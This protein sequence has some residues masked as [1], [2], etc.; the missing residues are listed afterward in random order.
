MR[1]APACDVFAVLTS[2]DAEAFAQCGLTN[3][4]V[5]PNPITWN[6]SASFTRSPGKYI[7]FIGR[8]SPE[9]GPDLA[10][11]GFEQARAQL[12]PDTRLRMIGAGPLEAELREQAGPQVEFVAP[13]ADIESILSESAVLLLTSRTEGAPLVVAE[14]LAAGVPVIATDCSAGVREFFTNNDGVYTD[15][16]ARENPSAIAESLIRFSRAEA[17]VIPAKSQV[18]GSGYEN[19]SAVFDSL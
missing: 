13:L 6:P 18:S 2:E 7:D 5:I 15:L 8:F 11:V 14:A 1:A 4:V 3:V 12:G 9:K 10:L 19:W 16:I 17:I